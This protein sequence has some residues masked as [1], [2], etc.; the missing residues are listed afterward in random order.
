MSLRKSL[1]VSTAVLAAALSFAPSLYA[2]ANETFTVKIT[3]I[4][5]GI[6]FTPFLAATHNN[7]VKLFEVAKPASDELSRVAEGGD[8][9]PLAS[10]L[11]ATGNVIDT[12]TTSGLLGPGESVSF[13]IQSQTHV[14]FIS[15]VSMLLPTNDTI[16]ALNKGVLPGFRTGTATYYLDAYDAGTEANDE[17]CENIPGPRCGGEPFSPEDEGE[18]YVYPSPGIHGDADLGRA[19]Y[20]WSGKVAK[21]E[22]V[23]VR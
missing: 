19:A 12:S 10:A 6:S 17:L 7:D 8:V 23:R 11:E 2:Q 3:N 5:K 9:G 4:T 14:S 15:I 18:G 13:D 1:V 22:I 16:V 21:V 20:N